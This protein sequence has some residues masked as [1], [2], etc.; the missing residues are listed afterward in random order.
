MTENQCNQEAEQVAHMRKIVEIIIDA[1]V[2]DPVILSSGKFPDLDSASLQAQFYEAAKTRRKYTYRM[3]LFGGALWAAAI[4]GL[5]FTDERIFFIAI[6]C[7]IGT[8][9]LAWLFSKERASGQYLDALHQERIRRW[10]AS[11][12]LRDRLEKEIT[13]DAFFPNSKPS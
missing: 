2:D 8:G 7:L 12:Q 10:D 3:F 4:W 9:I 13:W 5:K 1:A 6:G 11:K